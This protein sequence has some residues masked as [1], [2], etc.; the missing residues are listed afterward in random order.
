MGS[1]EGDY[2][3]AQV[4]RGHATIPD[5]AMVPVPGPAK[6]RPFLQFEGAAAALR[7]IKNDSVEQLGNGECVVLKVCEVMSLGVEQIV[8]KRSLVLKQKIQV[9]GPTGESA[10]NEA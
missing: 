7:W 4:I 1:G 5:G 3:I 10:D 6:D 8:Q 9:S 2:I